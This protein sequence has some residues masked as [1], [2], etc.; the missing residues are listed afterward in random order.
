MPSIPTRFET[1]L[2]HGP[3]ERDG[4]SSRTMR[5]PQTAQ[6][7]PGPCSYTPRNKVGLVNDSDSLSRKGYGSGFVSKSSRFAHSF[8]KAVESEAAFTPGPGY[9]SPQS[10]SET[11]KRYCPPPSTLSSKPGFSSSSTLTSSILQNTDTPGPGAYNPKSLMGEPLRLRRAPPVHLLPPRAML[12]A[13]SA[14]A[15]LSHR[16]AQGAPI[17]TS[18]APIRT[19]DDGF[20]SSSQR[21]PPLNKDTPAPGD[22]TPSTT[23]SSAKPF[24]SSVFRSRTRRAAVTDKVVFAVPSSSPPDIPGPGAYSVAS[25]ALRDGGSVADAANGVVTHTHVRL[26]SDPSLPSSMFALRTADRFGKPLQPKTKPSP[27]PAPGDYNPH[28]VTDLYPS[29]LNKIK[30]QRTMRAEAAAAAAEKAS[31]AAASALAAQ[32]N[33]GYPPS[34]TTSPS[35]T[36][37]LNRTTTTRSAPSIPTPLPPGVVSASP[38]IPGPGHYDI[39][40]VPLTSR[41]QSYHVPPSSKRVWM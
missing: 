6:D 8:V 39:A 4:F 16:R 36:S 38:P 29:L 10:V 27:T 5:F 11:N 2:N 18:F 9:Y 33:L 23:S 15:L 34:T 28:V 21:F 19:R 1:T 26:N 12:E 24:L 13:Q 22:Y 20:M 37:S 31:A 3:T 30:P 7:T 25:P 14:V 41:Q 17:P 40:N 35:T 32:R